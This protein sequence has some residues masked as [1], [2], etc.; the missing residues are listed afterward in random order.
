MRSKAPGTASG[1]VEETPDWDTVI[2]GTSLLA[3]NYG[4]YTLLV[5]C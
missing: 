3:E 1:T 5:R 2:I 4:T